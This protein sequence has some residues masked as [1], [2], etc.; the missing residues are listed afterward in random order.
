[1]EQNGRS[2]RVVPVVSS[3]FAGDDSFNIF[4]ANNGR[5]ALSNS[6]QNVREE[7]SGV[8]VSGSLTGAG[9]WLAREPAREDVHQSRKLA[10]RE[11]SQIA[12]D[13][14][15][16]Q[17]PAFHARKKVFDCEGFDL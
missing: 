1:M 2:C 12:P 10:P 7:V 14:S 5:S 4:K 17:L 3:E 16:V 13:R 9:E 6:L 15:R 11:G 8:F